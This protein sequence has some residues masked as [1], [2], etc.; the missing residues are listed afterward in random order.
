MYHFHVNI[1][2]H[3]F[4]ITWEQA[5]DSLQA[6]PRM[7]FEPD[8]SWVWSGG[9]RADRW[10]VDGHLFDFDGRLHRVELHGSCP[11]ESFDQLL[12]CFDWPQAEFTF[13]MVREGITLKESQFRQLAATE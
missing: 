2:A 6:L 3:P 7:I 13:E 8:G 1:F 11:E 12:A 4:Q 10:Q 9:V 5:A